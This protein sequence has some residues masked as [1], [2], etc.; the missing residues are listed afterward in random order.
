[1]TA[2]N[3]QVSN[4]GVL[5][6]DTPTCELD[7]IAEQVRR[8]GY[9]TLD[10]GFSEAELILLS[11]AFDRTR[12]I[13]ARNWGEE[14]LRSINE[15]NTIRA[16]LVHG[17][18][19]FVKLASNANLM[20]LLSKLIGGK[21]VLN[22]Q[23]GIINPPNESYNQ[24]VWHRDLP[25]QHFISDTPLAINALYCVDDF[26][27]ENGATLVLP[28]THKTANFPSE[29][30]IK[31]NAKYVEAKA[32]QFIVLDCM[33]FH[34]GGF[35]STNSQR[36]AV[37]HVYTIP[38]FKQQIKLPDMMKNQKLSSA[39]KELFGFSLQEPTSIEQYLQ[40]RKP[41]HSNQI[42]E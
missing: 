26:T 32:G 36:R 11:E 28:A 6:K 25:Y 23:N 21:F 3:P 41:S 19:I 15:H 20:A 4:Y 35:N 2:N 12:Q 16:P 31:R 30:F 39:E 10:S 9:A 29:V 42:R 1:M 17:D 24:A 40:R 8:L 22:Q 37:N 18:S 33:I 34:S 14:Q 27:F 38:Y 13:Y 5:L 7:D